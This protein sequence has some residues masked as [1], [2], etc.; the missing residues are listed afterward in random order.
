M[1]ELRKEDDA[2]KLYYVSPQNYEDEPVSVSVETTIN[3]STHLLN[4]FVCQVTQQICNFEPQPSGDT[5]R[6]DFNLFD[7][8]EFNP[9]FGPLEAIPL[10]E[11]SNIMII[12]FLSFTYS[13]MYCHFQNNEPNL[14]LT[15]ID[16]K[17][18]DGDPDVNGVITFTLDSDFQGR[19]VHHG[20]ASLLKMGV[21]LITDNWQNVSG[22]TFPKMAK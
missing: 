1:F 18:A 17:D 3:F 15:E 14:L 12:V 19:L 2:F 7:V 4:N 20:E 5:Q 9:E 21:I 22:S 10:P 13:Y 8:N 11:V 16:A 6:T